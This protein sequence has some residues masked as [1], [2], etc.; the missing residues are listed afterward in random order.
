MVPLRRPTNCK[1]ACL[2]GVRTLSQGG[3]MDGGCYSLRGARNGTQDPHFNQW[4]Q[5]PEAEATMVPLL[6][7]LGRLA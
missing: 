5:R 2:L 1:M 7:R 4:D 3:W 6:T